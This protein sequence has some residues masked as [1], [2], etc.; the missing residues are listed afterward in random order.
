MILGKL[1]Y[2]LR[3]VVTCM[4]LR[5][6]PPPCDELGALIIAGKTGSID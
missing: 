4:L 3:E 2:E 1:P 5:S 6:G